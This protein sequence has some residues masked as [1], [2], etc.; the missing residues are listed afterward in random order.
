M[1]ITAPGGIRTGVPILSTYLGNLYGYGSGTSQAAAHVTGA[2]ALKLQQKPQ[3][4]LSE[5]QVLL[6][7]TATDLGYP[8]MQ[9]GSGLIDVEKMLAA[10]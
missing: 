8:A 5:V 2:I 3:I 10:P 9:Q 7:Q 4:S 6:K 1:D